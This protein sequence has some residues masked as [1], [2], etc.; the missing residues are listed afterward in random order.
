MGGLTIDWGN[1]VRQI[2][3]FGGRGAAMR[4]AGTAVDGSIARGLGAAVASCP[5]ILWDEAGEAPTLG[6]AAQSG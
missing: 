2:V 3:S 5:V 4:D 6:F 1:G